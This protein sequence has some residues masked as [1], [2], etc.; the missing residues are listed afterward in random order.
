MKLLHQMTI[1]TTRTTNPYAK[2]FFPNHVESFP[3]SVERL[4]QKQI[5]IF[6]EIVLEWRTI[7][8]LNEVLHQWE[9]RNKKN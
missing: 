9:E 6:Q 5:K 8:T 7:S 3:I 4:S 1:T 2:E